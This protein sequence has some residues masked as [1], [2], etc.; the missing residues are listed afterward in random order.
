[1]GLPQ[2]IGLEPKVNAISV[3]RT[4]IRGRLQELKNQPGNG[5]LLRTE[6]QLK[7][8]GYTEEEILISL[9]I[10]SIESNAS[11]SSAIVSLRSDKME[12][13]LRTK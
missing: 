11:L 5:L 13:I 10:I 8:L 1:M 9:L 4:E 12:N 3:Q 2:I 6:G 7:S